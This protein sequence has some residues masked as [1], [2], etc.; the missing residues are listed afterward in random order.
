MNR[1]FKGM[2][3]LMDDG[4][5]SVQVWKEFAP[6]NGGGTQRFEEKAPSMHEAVNTLRAMVTVSPHRRGD[7]AV[8][9]DPTERPGVFYFDGVHSNAGR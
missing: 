9:Q 6:E 4:T 5:W 7:I 2:I 8:P 3:E 1:I